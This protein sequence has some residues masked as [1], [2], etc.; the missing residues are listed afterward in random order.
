MS[1][2]GNVGPESDEEITS[3][4]LFRFFLHLS[5]LPL[6]VDS[7]LLLNSKTEVECFSIYLWESIGV[8][9]GSESTD[10]LDLITL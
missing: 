6:V 4:L 5:T 10:I 8:L 2:A 9:G 7:L 3:H 1:K